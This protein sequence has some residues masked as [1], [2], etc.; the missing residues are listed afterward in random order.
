MSRI[1]GGAGGRIKPGAQE[2]GRLAGAQGSGGGRAGSRGSEKGRDQT[3]G[4]QAMCERADPV[5]R[6]RKAGGTF[7][8]RWER[9]PGG[10]PPGGD[11]EESV[12]HQSLDGGTSR[13]GDVLFLT[14]RTASPLV[15]Q[16]LHLLFLEPSGKHS[17]YHTHFCHKWRNY[18]WTQRVGCFMK[19]E[20][21]HTSS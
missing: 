5:H 16:V 6:E 15:K 1:Y 2:G 7:C 3:C 10:R 17:I 14:V 19:N 21:G 9:K 11:F 12:G 8:F 20:R 4:Q 18:R 13:A